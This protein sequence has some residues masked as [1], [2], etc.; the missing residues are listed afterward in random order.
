MQHCP[1]EH[2]PGDATHGAEGSAWVSLAALVPLR[3]LQWAEHSAEV[4]LPAPI[5]ALPLW[6]R[7]PANAKAVT[8]ERCTKFAE[9]APRFH[10]E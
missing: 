1:L 4:P 2:N 6:L 7:D 5:G 8:F 3:S 9:R 10:P